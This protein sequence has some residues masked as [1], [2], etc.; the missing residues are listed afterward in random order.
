MGRTRSVGQTLLS[1]DILSA[2]CIVDV[3]I[4]A[5]DLL[6]IAATGEGISE[7][8]KQPAGS[9]PAF[10][11]VV[12]QIDG[13]VEVAARN[14]ENLQPISS[15]VELSDLTRASL[16]VGGPS[17]QATAMFGRRR[18]TPVLISLERELEPVDQLRQV[19]RRARAIAG[20]ARRR[21]G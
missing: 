18:A 2:G 14:A 5:D 7:L 17:V 11:I 3:R 9:S 8:E 6:E 4:S 19:A 1:L 20:A 16:T 21:I 13:I 12:E 15:A 10:V